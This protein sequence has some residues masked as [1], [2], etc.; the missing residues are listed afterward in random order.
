M[1]DQ[2]RRRRE[3]HMQQGLFVPPP[4][5][6]RRDLYKHDVMAQANLPDPGPVL[7]NEAT[8]ETSADHHSRT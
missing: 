8:L 1:Q 2:R 7:Q 4:D 6:C 5:N 3:Q